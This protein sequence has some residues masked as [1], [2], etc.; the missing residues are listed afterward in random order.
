MYVYESKKELSIRTMQ[1]IDCRFFTAMKDKVM[2]RALDILN[3]VSQ[4]GMQFPTDNDK[5][6]QYK[7]CL[8][9]AFLYNVVHLKHL[10][11]Q[12]SF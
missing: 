6:S 1:A 10:F 11:V 9:Q 5:S 12:I 4:H 7:S 8:K 2:W 3:T